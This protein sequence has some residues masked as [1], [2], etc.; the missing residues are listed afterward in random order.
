MKNAAHTPGNWTINSR[1]RI[2]LHTD[3]DGDHETLIAEVFDEHDWWRANARLL[4]AAPR[5]LRG[6]TR[7]RF[8]S[9]AAGDVIK[10]VNP[11][12]EREV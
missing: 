8:A 9:R 2:S 3:E 5:L 10:S 1:Q 7:S 4:R 6:A 11:Q 12:K